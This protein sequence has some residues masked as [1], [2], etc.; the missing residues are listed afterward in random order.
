M[1]IRIPLVFIIKYELEKEMNK[2]EKHDNYYVLSVI[3]N[4]RKK[5][6]ESCKT[7]KFLYNTLSN[8]F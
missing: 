1:F 7:L 4:T 8:I 5:K 6:E 2:K 3:N